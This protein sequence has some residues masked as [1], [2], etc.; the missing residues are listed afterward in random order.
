MTCENAMITQPI[1]VNMTDTVKDV[2]QLL[3]KHKI[4]AVPVV[5][6]EDV[7]VGMFGIPHILYSLLPIS[8]RMEDGLRKLNFVMGAMPDIAEHLNDIMHDA[9][10]THINK[11]THVLHSDTSLMESVRILV[12]YGGP[13]PVVA[14]GTGK[15]EGLVTEQSILQGIKS[16]MVIQ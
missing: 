10:E 1:K 6:N 11:D 5:N 14:K 15:L 2:L 13:V 9:I 8:A 12:K 3:E 4:R 7:L 16:A